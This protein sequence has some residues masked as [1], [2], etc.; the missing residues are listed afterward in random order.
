VA[1]SLP[2]TH[3]TLRFKEIGVSQKYWCLR[4][5]LELCVYNPDGECLHSKRNDFSYKIQ[6][7]YT[8]SLWQDL[9]MR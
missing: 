2:S 6:T 5:V 3:P 4:V 7:W 8:N 1:D 9:G